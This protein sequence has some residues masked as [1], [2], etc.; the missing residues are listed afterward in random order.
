[1]MRRLSLALGLLASVAPSLAAVAASSVVVHKYDGDVNKGSYIV[2]VRDG[3]QKSGVM[4]RITSLLGGN[5]KV[6]HDWDSQFF[7]GFA[8]PSLGPCA[9]VVFAP[10]QVLIGNFDDTVIEVLKSTVDVEYIAED[11]IV[12]TLV[13]QYVEPRVSDSR[14]L[15]L[16]PACRKNAPW[17]LARVNT[18]ARLT[19]QDPL[20]LDYVYSY[21]ENPGHGV[22]I[23]VVDTGSFFRS[24]PS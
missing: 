23:Y 21:L 4:S 3:A 13:D 2:K 6:T 8:G 20:A 10:D 9:R 16:K 18:R 7:N 19:N 24:F 22:D 12:K 15:L 14:I 1:M 5:T 11:G 17:N